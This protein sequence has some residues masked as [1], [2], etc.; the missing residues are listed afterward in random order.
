MKVTDIKAFPLTVP[1]KKSVLSAHVPSKVIV[2]VKILTD[3]GVTGFGEPCAAF[4]TAPAIASLVEHSLRPYLIGRSPLEIEEI[5]GEM[6]RGTFNFGRT[7]LAICAMSGIEQALWDIAGKMYGIPIYQM[8]GGPSKRPLKA[9]ASL[10]RYNSTKD[11][12][13]AL[14]EC[15]RVGYTAIKLHQSDVPSVKLAREVLGDNIDLMVDVNGAWKPYEAVE[16]IKKLQQYGIYWIEEP[17][18]PGDDYEG[19]ASVRSS[20]DV[21]IALGE[22]E[23]NLFGFREIAIK[24]AA[25]IIQPCVSKIGIGQAKRALTIA[26]AW[27]LAI[28][29]HCFFLGPALPA[30]LHLSVTDPECLFM[31][32]PISPLEMEPFLQPLKPKSGYWEL[33]DSPGLGIEINEEILV[34]YPYT[35]GDTIPFWCR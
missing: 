21:P 16:M 23:Y 22:N 13:L 35:G 12:A 34:R 6:Y 8:L 28:S 11:L 27:N 31:E 33:S 30:S 18:W 29:P 1:F 25:D 17:V 4:R 14:E 26:H 15:M 5:W 10:Y 7:G 9:Y 32:T 24:K 3:E 2:L 20:I 19:L